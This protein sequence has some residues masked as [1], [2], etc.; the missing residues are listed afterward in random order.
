[1]IYAIRVIKRERDILLTER[2]RIIKIINKDKHQTKESEA[3]IYELDRRRKNLSEARLVL[4]SFIKTDDITGRP[5]NT[6]KK[7]EEQ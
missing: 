2:K 7:P 6:I 1:M 4:E 3:A 5:E